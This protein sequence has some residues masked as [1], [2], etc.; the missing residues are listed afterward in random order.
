LYRI[1][2]KPTVIN[3]LQVAL[4]T[5]QHSCCQQSAA[6]RG[7]LIVAGDCCL[8]MVIAIYEIGLIAVGCH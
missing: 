5:H 2:K 1:N 7:C 8:M 6:V 4:Q 3:E